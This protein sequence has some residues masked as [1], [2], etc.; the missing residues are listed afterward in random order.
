M[1][2]R[3]WAGSVEGWPGSGLVAL[4]IPCL[5]A[6]FQGPWLLPRTVA[7]N[8]SLAQDPEMKGTQ[9]D[10]HNGRV[11]FNLVFSKDTEFQDVLTL[12]CSPPQLR[13]LPSVAALLT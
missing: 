2:L 1:H 12:G 7:K 11:Q 13:G 8:R 10:G 9:C 4:G 6:L 5:G 3:A